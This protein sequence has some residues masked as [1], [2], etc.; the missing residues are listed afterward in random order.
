MEESFTDNH[1]R[2][3][4]YHISDERFHSNYDAQ[5]YCTARYGSTLWCPTD[6]YEFRAIF[7]NLGDSKNRF[8]DPEMHTGVRREGGEDVHS[9]MYG[10]DGWVCWA[11]PGIT[12]VYTEFRPGHP[13]DVAH[14]DDCSMLGAHLN[15]RMTDVQCGH[16]FLRARAVCMTTQEPTHDDIWELDQDLARLEKHWE[17]HKKGAIIVVILFFLFIIGCCKCCC[18][19][20]AEAPPPAPAP[21]VMQAPQPQVPRPITP[22][23]VYAAPPPPQP[24]YAPP[25]PQPMYNPY[26]APPSPQPA[27]NINIANN[28]T[29]TN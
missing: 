9:N 29:N 21:V 26:A 18:G 10:D 28:N 19:G 20:K 17:D 8:R 4:F 5:D 16:A 7:L 24:M 15:R 1:G 25:P 27:F 14:G 6:E 22:Q 12:N 3:K 23:P 2:D 11:N 13:R